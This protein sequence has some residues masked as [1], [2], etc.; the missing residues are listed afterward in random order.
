MTEEADV[1]RV[2]ALFNNVIDLVV[3][4]REMVTGPMFADCMLALAQVIACLHGSSGM[5]REQTAKSL[6]RFCVIVMGCSEAGAEKRPQR[7]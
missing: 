3:D 4:D 2:E 1:E 7:H 5:S 6:A